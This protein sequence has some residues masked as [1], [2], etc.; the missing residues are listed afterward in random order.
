M[1]AIIND[2]LDFSKVEAGKLILENIDFDII[3]LAEEVA[4]LVAWKA[5]DKGLIMT[6]FI[7]PAIP[8][9]LRGD[10]G[11][12]RQILLNIASNA[13]KFTEA[14]EI[15][16]RALRV[17]YDGEPSHIRFE[18]EDTGIGLSPEARS[19]LFQPF[20][21]A[22]G[23][24][25]RKYGGTGLGLSI[26]K[27][28][29]DLMNGDIGVESSEGHGSLFYFTIPLREALVT[30][31]VCPISRANLCGIKVLIVNNHENSK[32]IIYRYI[33]AWG[34][35]NSVIATPQEAVA[36]LKRDVESSDP[37]DLAIID[38]VTPLV[39]A[40]DLVQMIKS[41][42]QL[43]ETKV[44]MLTANDAVGLKETALQ[45]GTNGYLVKPVKQSELFDCIA[46][47]MNRVNQISVTSDTA[48]T[49]ANLPLTNEGMS[50]NSHTVLLAEDNFANQ[51]LAMLLLTKLGYQVRL[52]I[53]GQEAVEITGRGEI[54]LILMDCQMPKMDGFEATAAIRQ[55]EQIARRHIP[56]IAMTANAMQGDRE[57]CLS[58]G[59]DDYI[60]KPINSKQLKKLLERWLPK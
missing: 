10:P 52:A 51:K 14:G 16:I 38:S 23:S 47:A 13:V 28:L 21:Q 19:R 50:E 36:I 57:K 11:R 20:T 49:V 31:N 37:Y 22:D 60:S 12:L 8:P 58:S 34:M 7:D 30:H 44:V 6:T 25:T 43:R 18:I 3:T 2:V 54:D 29:V 5:R 48:A 9:L 56:I 53:N 35:R 4:D 55:E 26:S 59:M 27:R 24:T 1:L 17:D 32:D 45:A 33:C 41:D 40:L 42:P 15:V 39:N 46:V